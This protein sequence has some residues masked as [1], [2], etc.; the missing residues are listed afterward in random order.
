[1]KGGFGKFLTFIL[2]LVVGVLLVGG[3][4]AGVVYYAVAAVSVNDV[5]SIRSVTSSISGSGRSGDIFSRI[6]RYWFW[7]RRKSKSGCRI[8]IRWA[9]LCDTLPSAQLSQQ[10]LIEK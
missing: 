6:G 1:M 7:P 8:F 5:E 2:G 10:T 4:I 9:L 3:T